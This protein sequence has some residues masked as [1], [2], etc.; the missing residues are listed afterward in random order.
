MTGLR[1]PFGDNRDLSCLGCA[2]TTPDSMFCPHCG[3]PLCFNCLPPDKH[4]CTDPSGGDDAEAAPKTP[5]TDAHQ[6]LLDAITA[7][8]KLAQQA[9]RVEDWRTAR[10]N[11]VWAGELNMD[12]MP[13]PIGQMFDTSFAGFITANDPAQIVR[14]TAAHL[15]I[16]KRHKPGYWGGEPEYG[17]HEETTTTGKLVQVR[18]DQPD[19]PDCCE[20]CAE[21]W[22]CPDWLDVAS[23]Y[24]AEVSHGVDRTAD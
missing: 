20:C 17:Y 14:D 13:V 15:R 16:A 5:T 2:T 8:R 9:W 11:E 18:N 4:V 12:H 23:S 24:P 19:P 7:R 10:H 3:S 22:P 21:A 6:R 1:P